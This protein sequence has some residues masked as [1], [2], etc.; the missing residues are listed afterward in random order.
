MKFLDLDGL[1]Y[2][3]TKLMEKL[4]NIIREIINDLGFKKVNSSTTNGNI[5][6]D[7]VE[8]KV[9]T[10]PNATTS[11]VGGV[12]VGTNVSVSNGIISVNNGSTSTKGVVQLTDSTSST[13]T[14][15]AATPNSVKTAYDLATTAKTNADTAL[16]TADSKVGSVSITTGTN[17]GTIKLTVDGTSTDN[18]AVK[19]LGNA[20]YTNSSAYATSGHTHNYAGSSSAGGSANSAVK[21]DTTTAG[22]ETQP[23]YFE[24]GKPSPCTYTL[25]KS[26]PSDAK[27]T[28][29][30]YTHPS[31]HAASMITG[32]ATVATSGKYSDLT[33]QPTIPTKTSQLTNDSGF[34]TTDTTYSVVSTTADGLAPKR[35]GSTTK[36]L[37]ADGTWAVPPDNNT[38]YT[39][40]TTSGNKHIP[41]G[42]SSGQILRWASDG[43]AAWG[44]DNNTTYTLSSFGVTATAAELNALDGITATVTE[45]NYTDGVTSNI[46][47][48]LNGKAASSHTHNYA[49][50][51]SPGGSATVAEKAKSANSAVFSIPNNGSSNVEGGELQLV[52]QDGT[53]WSVDSLSN[54]FRIFDSKGNIHLTCTR[55][56]P[57]SSYFSGKAANADAVNGFS[58]NSSTGNH[59]RPINYGT[60]ALTPGTSALTTG[61]I[62][63]QYE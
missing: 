59:L 33:G 36:F 18:I 23:V 49:G 43:T 27:F 39:H 45:L 25:G 51:S 29:T 12:K 21:L 11:D 6:I 46:Q 16:S 38:V 3:T 13:S 7:N 2:F 22:S 31:T 63:L 1:S 28:D 15:T 58:V 44:A 9:Y 4:P 62:Y 55:G 8:T 52:N 26:V 32:L 57:S 34:K 54:N 30:V 24:D 35:D 37:R 53:Y 17:N 41:S 5:L 40:P 47:T 61:Y 60:S 19:G 50:S 10:L 56:T 14:T 48:Q 42:G 20:A